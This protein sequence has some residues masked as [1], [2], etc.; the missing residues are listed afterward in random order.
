MGSIK[1]IGFF[2]KSFFKKVLSQDWPILCLGKIAALYMK[3]VYK[4]TKWS[5]EGF[6]HPEA[7]WAKNQP[8]I[9]CFWHNRLFM[10]AFCWSQDRPFHMLI[11]GHKDGRLIAK[12]VGFYGI[13]AIHGSTH[14]KGTEALRSM[15]RI[16]KSGETIGMTPDGPRGPAFQASKGVL[17]LARLSGVPILPVT[18]SLERRKVFQTWDRFILPLP[19]GR[20]SLAWGEPLYFSK[21]SEDDQNRLEK[22]MNDL[23]RRIDEKHGHKPFV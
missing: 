15:I 22:A 2:L 9:A 23:C 20:G 7:M 10:T 6:E 17:T 21:S 14:K 18:Y 8:F 11:S 12:I 13:K 5:Y 16:L 3:I 4:T 19:G 1:N